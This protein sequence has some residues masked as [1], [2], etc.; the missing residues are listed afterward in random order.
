MT[1][2]RR[3]IP[4]LLCARLTRPSL[5]FEFVVF[6]HRFLKNNFVQPCFKY[7]AWSHFETSFQSRKP[8]LPVRQAGCLPT[9]FRD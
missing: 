7:Y 1:K 2:K 8:A 5:G 4:I 3:Q 9:G 6:A